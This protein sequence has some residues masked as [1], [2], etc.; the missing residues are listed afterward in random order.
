M[1][2]TKGRFSVVIPTMQRASQLWP[3]VEQCS[4]HP[5]VHEVLV[6]N[7]SRDPLSWDLPN[8][9]VLQQERNIFVNPAWNL[10]VR[11]AQGE[12]LA[13]L[14]DDILPLE[15][16]LGEVSRALRWKR[17]VGLVGLHSS[18][19]RASDASTK[20]WRPAYER[21]DGYGVAMF[22]RRVDYVPIPDD[23]KV[24]YGDDWL[25]SRQRKRNWVLGGFPVET[26]MSAT[27]SSPVFDQ[28]KASDEEAWHR[29]GPGVNDSLFALERRAVAPLK[30]LRA[31]IRARFSL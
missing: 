28:I 10:G 15:D 23:M 9:R 13:I 21:T 26:E 18:C 29:H 1:T 2:E 20:W 17:L 30:G 24:W 4:G 7:N 5:L 22:L 25:M 27:S 12:F 6:V 19:F 3:L 8:V 11:T 14:N 16:L 31:R